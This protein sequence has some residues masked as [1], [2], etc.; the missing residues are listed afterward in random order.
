M[1]FR[2]LHRPVRHC[3]LDAL[4]GVTFKEINRL[5]PAV[6]LGA[7]VSCRHHFH[8]GMRLGCVPRS[9]IGAVVPAPSADC[10]RPCHP[11][12]PIISLCRSVEREALA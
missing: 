11:D 4:G 3:P 5:S 6:A 10:V 9:R 7:G 1:A 12:P 2:W 8:G